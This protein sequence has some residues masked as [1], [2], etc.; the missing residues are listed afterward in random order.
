MRRLSQIMYTKSLVQREWNERTLCIQIRWG[1]FWQ[2]KEKIKE[3]NKQKGNSNHPKTSGVVEREMC[4]FNRSVL[5]GLNRA[6]WKKS[7]VKND[8]FPCIDFDG[9]SFEF[10]CFRSVG[11]WNKKNDLVGNL[12]FLVFLG[13]MHQKDPLYWI[14]IDFLCPSEICMIL[15]ILRKLTI[16]M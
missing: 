11:K 12:H 6:K 16:M 14:Q 8:C 2:I 15:R 7:Q 1:G 13:K 10:L 5:E 9:N 3:K 4:C